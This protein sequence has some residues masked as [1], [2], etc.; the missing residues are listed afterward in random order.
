MKRY[1][2]RWPSQLAAALI[3]AGTLGPMVAFA[4]P[5]EQSPD[6]NIEPHAGPFSIHDLDQNGLLSR[7][8]YGQ[9]LTA[10][11]QRRKAASESGRRYSPP[12]R[13]EEI[14]RNDDGSLSEDE[15]ISA[16]NRRLERHQRYRNR[17]GRW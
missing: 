3:L 15:M 9:F 13:F 6:A 12:L 11:E 2:T 14:D 5:P 17:S 16:L 8:E 1:D 7:D 4:A 10:V